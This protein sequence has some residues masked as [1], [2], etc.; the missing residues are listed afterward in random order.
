MSWTCSF[1]EFKDSAI[2]LT[3]DAQALAAAVGMICDGECRVLTLAGNLK[4]EF[5]GKAIAGENVARIHREE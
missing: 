3:F 4:A 1:R 5:G 2:S